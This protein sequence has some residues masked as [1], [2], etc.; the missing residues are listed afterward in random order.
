M[1]A[2]A[3]RSGSA[4]PG[5]PRPA[6]G[7]ALSA[8]P[9]LPTWRSTLADERRD[10][11]ASRGQRRVGGPPLP[12]AQGLLDVQLV[13]AEYQHVEVAVLADRPA[14]GELDRIPPA[15]HHGHGI[16]EKIAAASWSCAGSQGPCGAVMVLT[17]SGSFLGPARAKLIRPPG[18]ERDR[19]MPSD[20]VWKLAPCIWSLRAA[21]QATSEWV[22][23]S[24]TAEA[25][26]FKISERTEADYRLWVW[27]TRGCWRGFKDCGAADPAAH[28]STPSSCQT[29]TLQPPLRLQLGLPLSLLPRGSMAAEAQSRGRRRRR[30]PGQRSLPSPDC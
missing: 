13:L 23:T 17:R 8:R 18:F 21:S 30:R 14:D 9:G 12:A 26:A 6:H 29:A 24:T 15:I 28:P 10:L 16:A 19:R 5:K 27:P 11:K 3:L 4:Q 1:T 20:V 7:L 25:R 22:A 2:Q